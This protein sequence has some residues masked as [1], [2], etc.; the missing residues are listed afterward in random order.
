M[1]EKKMAFKQQQERIFENI[2]SSKRQDQKNTFHESNDE[3]VHD[4]KTLSELVENV[5]E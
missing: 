3:H 5:I 1:D 2:C 4:D